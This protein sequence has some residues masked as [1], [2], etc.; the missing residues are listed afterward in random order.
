MNPFPNVSVT[1]GSAF[2]EGP[3]HACAPG[4]ENR[5]Q[6]LTVL[7]VYAPE[8][9]ASRRPTGTLRLC[10]THTQTL[11]EHLARGGVTREI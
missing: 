3:C 11:I 7:H 8:R 2:F 9:E 4:E 1:T 5:G 10:A 6:L